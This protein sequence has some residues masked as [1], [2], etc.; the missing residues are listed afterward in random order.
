MAG[1]YDCQ[2]LISGNNI[3]DNE[4]SYG[5]GLYGCHG[6]ITNNLIHNNSADPS[7]GYGGGIYYCQGTI[8][9]NTVHDNSA[10]YGGGISESHG[11]ISDNY[12][13]SNDSVYGGGLYNCSGTVERN[14]II[15]N[16]ATDGGGFYSSSGTVQNNLIR[17]N[18]ATDD[19]G[20][21]YGMH[22]SFAHNTLYGNTAGAFG[23]GLSNCNAD[24]F[25]NNIFRANT[26]P[27]DPQIHNSVD[28]NYSSI[29]AWAGGGTG[30]ITSN[31]MFYSLSTGDFHLAAGSPCINTGN[32]EGVG[33][34]YDGE[35]R[36]FGVAPDMGYDEFVDTDEDGLPDEWEERNN[37]NP[38]VSNVGLDSDDDGLTDVEEYQARTDPDD[39]DSDND[40]FRD[41]YEVDEG[42]NPLDSGEFPDEIWMYFAWTGTENGRQL[43]PYNTVT[44]AVTAVDPGGLIRGYPGSQAG[45]VYINKALRMEAVGGTVRIGA[46]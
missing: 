32:D 11:T 18:S 37:L 40:G 20:G 6:T 8:S 3:H 29:Q 45:A 2:G 46:N 5:G 34:D 30:N 21:V 23:G 35:S 27:V 39:E 19:G 41:G 16:D 24:P 13:H 9:N 44:E 14:R 42:T 28:P 22:G 1:L 43:F 38:N 4:A 26:A 36:P 25:S 10:A 31:P 7:F 12:V 17:G 33:D 15:G